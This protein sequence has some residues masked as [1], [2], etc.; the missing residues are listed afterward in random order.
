MCE[1]YIHV[2]VHTK[3]KTKSPLSLYLDSWP[4][5]PPSSPFFFILLTKYTTLTQ[6]LQDPTQDSSSTRN[7]ESGV[8]WFR[9]GRG[10]FG[11]E[12]S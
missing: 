7:M 12:A 5:L 8:H 11:L 6:P 9:V 1:E 3:H 10:Y 4:L 2:C